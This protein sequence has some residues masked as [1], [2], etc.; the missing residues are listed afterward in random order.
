MEL[1]L[2]IRDGLS[3]TEDWEFLTNHCEQNMSEERIMEFLSDDTMHLFTTNA[4]NNTHNMNQ[5]QQINE[6]FCLI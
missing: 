3:T 2:R 6:N 1:L 5:I 4:D